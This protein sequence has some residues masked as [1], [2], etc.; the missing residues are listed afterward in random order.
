M[1]SEAGDVECRA[2]EPGVPGQRE[3]ADTAA[4]ASAAEVERPHDGRCHLEEDRRRAPDVRGAEPE[5]VRVTVLDAGEDMLIR[6]GGEAARGARVRAGCAREDRRRVGAHAVEVGAG[7]PAVA[8][9]A[10][11]TMRRDDG[12]RQHHVRRGG[13][14][15]GGG[16]TDLRDEVRVGRCVLVG[17]LPGHGDGAELL[18]G[19]LPEVVEVVRLRGC[20]EWRQQGAQGVLGQLL[21]EF[22]GH[23]ACPFR[24][25]SIRSTL[26]VRSW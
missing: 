9:S 13:F 8:V 5:G 21:E 23:R 4:E 10:D 20:G 14:P 25:G 24:R 22:L 1:V 3:R 7:A 2:T 15:R 12:A 26:P 11:E 6:D 18:E 19:R 16:E 17:E